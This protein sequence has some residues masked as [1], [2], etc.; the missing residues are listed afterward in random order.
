MLQGPEISTRRIKKV[1]SLYQHSREL[2]S[3]KRQLAKTG[4]SAVKAER[5][6]A[7]R[8]QVEK[9]IEQLCRSLE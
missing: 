4:L 2:E 6:I 7:R 9:K 1:D 5:L 3:I 8:L